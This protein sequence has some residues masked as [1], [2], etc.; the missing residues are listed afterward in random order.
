MLRLIHAAFVCGL[1]G[2][3]ASSF[4]ESSFPKSSQ[5]TLR[6][7]LGK[8]DEARARLRSREVS[9]GKWSVLIPGASFS[10]SQVIIVSKA[11]SEIKT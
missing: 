8:L 11:S 2:G 7:F 9:I 6:K 10:A 1:G 5:S 4:A 3:M